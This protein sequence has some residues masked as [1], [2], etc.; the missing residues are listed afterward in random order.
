MITITRAMDF[1]LHHKAVQEDWARIFGE[2]AG[3][4]PLDRIVDT[5]WV[6]MMQYR[7]SRVGNRGKEGLRELQLG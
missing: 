2:F 4:I 7:D 5:H 6:F 3:S 1:R